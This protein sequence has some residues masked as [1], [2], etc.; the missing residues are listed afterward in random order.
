MKWL[1]RIQ[2]WLEGHN[3]EVWQHLR[4][5]SRRVICHHCGGDWAQHDEHGFIDWSADCERMYS[6]Q[7]IKI[8]QRTQEREDE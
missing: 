3:M 2:C 6:G 4:P 5:W 8:R 1:R 7:G